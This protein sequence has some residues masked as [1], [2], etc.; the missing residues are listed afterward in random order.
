MVLFDSGPLI[1]IAKHQLLDYCITKFGELL[2]PTDVVMEVVTIGL[3]RGFEEAK[4][5]RT[6]ISRKNIK[7]QKAPERLLKEVAKA[8]SRLGLQLGKGEKGAIALALLK[9]T[10][11]L[12]DDQDASI[13][14]RALRIRARGVLY[15]TLL[16]LRNKRLTK[17]EAYLLIEKLIDQGMWL[18]PTIV[19]NFNKV[20]RRDPL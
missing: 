12:T 16:A 18:A 9:H 8:E 3:R 19:Q 13:V 7:V 4:T 20:V 17:E 5:V 6:A 10:E 2:I 14:A 1:R 11:L 15:I